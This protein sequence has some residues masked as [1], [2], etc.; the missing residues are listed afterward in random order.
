MVIEGGVGEENI[1][2]QFFNNNGSKTNTS[3]V[4]KNLHA[5]GRMLVVTR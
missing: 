5:T 2:Q 4:L 1:G 3:F